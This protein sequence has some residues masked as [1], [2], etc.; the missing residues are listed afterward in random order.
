MLCIG[1]PPSVRC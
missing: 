1:E